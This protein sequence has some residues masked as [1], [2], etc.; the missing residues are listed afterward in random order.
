MK[1]IKPLLLTL[2]FL[3][4]GQLYAQDVHW[5]LF[6]FAPLNVNPAQ[7]ADFEGTFRIGGIYRDQARAVSN[8]A[9]YT[10]PNIHVDAPLFM[11]GKKSWV[12]LGANIF[13]DKAGTAAL[14]TTSA[15]LS[16]AM[17]IPTNRKGTTV[18]SFGLQGGMVNQS[19][20]RDELRFGDGFIEQ[21]GEFQYD[22]TNA[23]STQNMNIEEEGSYIEF[24]SGVML[25]SALNKQTDMRLGLSVLHIPNAKYSLLQGNTPSTDSTSSRL[26]MRVNL[27]GNFDFALNK[28][29]TLSPGFLYSQMRTSNNIQVQGMMG[30]LFNPE[31]DITL[32][33][34]LGYRMR[35]AVEWLVGID[36]KQFRVGASYDMTL[37][38]LNEV[39]KYAGGFELGVSYI[40]VIFKKAEVKPVIFCPRF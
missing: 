29:W 16:A 6:N 1:M 22:P 35:D 37:S 2:T 23:G 26:P 38:G 14:R 11:V 30:Y 12:G 25:Q 40:A 39:N 28:K 31:K 4:A 3:L 27:H 13:S 19:I 8:D 7:T 18:F 33:F 17:H 32:N 36:Y 10:T 15:Q 9:T 21:G 20:D 34:G 24:G 5:S